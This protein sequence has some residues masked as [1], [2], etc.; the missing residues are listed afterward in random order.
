MKKNVLTKGILLL[1]VV[2]L[3]AIGFTGCSIVVPPVVPS[4]S[5]GTVIVYISGY[6]T[7]YDYD[8]YLDSGSWPIG[9]TWGGSYLT[10]T[11]ITPGW[12]TFYAYDTTWGWYWDSGYVYV[13]AGQTSTLTLYPTYHL[14]Y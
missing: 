4:I 7:G 3:L 11:N 1:V 10:A 9:T 8:I 5:T 6:Y 12:H 13:T 2:A 14:I